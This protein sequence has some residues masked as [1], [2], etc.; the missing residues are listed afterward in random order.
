MTTLQASSQLESFTRFPWERGV[1]GNIAW[2]L[3]PRYYPRLFKTKIYYEAY[4]E[5]QEEVDEMARRV[6]ISAKVIYDP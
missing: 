4:P 1:Y 5:S 2:T 6:P 3:N